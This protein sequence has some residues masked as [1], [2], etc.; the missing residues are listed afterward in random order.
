MNY[1]ELL[2]SKS[3]GR[4]NKTRLPLGEYYRH[5]VDGKWCGHVDIRQEL[6][7]NVVFSEAL[8][9]ECER[10]RTL[11]NRHQLHFEAEERDGDVV[12]LKIEPGNYL[13]VRQLLTDEPSLVA[14]RGFMDSLLDGLVDISSYLHSQGIWHVCY[15]PSSVLVRKGDNHVMLLSHGSFYLSVSN[16]EELYGDDACYVAPEVLR[17]GTV[18]ERCDVYS[19]GRFLEQIFGSSSIPLEFRQVLKRATSETPEDRYPTVQA[20]R[21]AVLKR[22]N[23]VKS[24]LA[25]AASLVVALICLGFYFD[26]VPE[27][28]PVEFVKPVPRQPYD[29][30]LEEGYG[31]DVDFTDSDSLTEEDRQTIREYQAK[32]E[33]IFRK[34]YEQEADRILNKI[35][36]RDNMSNSEK[37]FLS[38]SRSV[39]EELAKR[40]QELGDE[41]GISG[42]KASRIAAEINERLSNQK[43]DAL[44]GT[45]VYGIQK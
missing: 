34:K 30:L 13:S 40:Q 26:M 22:R 11:N 27:S 1:E 17:H 35:Y 19:I 14:E 43:R 10:N 21:S 36:N 20:L 25:L 23:G 6:N 4:M 9:K 18:D 33:A 5:Q 16:Q 31:G 29:D 38:K 15:S 28:E 3:D 41:A 39:S 24:L 44:G 42:E 8:K 32:A 12:G 45:N 37:I 2:A 7:E